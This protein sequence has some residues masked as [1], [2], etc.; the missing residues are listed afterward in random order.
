M[1]YFACIIAIISLCINGY[2]FLTADDLSPEIVKLQD[3]IKK[4]E[5]KISNLVV[6]NNDTVTG[7]ITRINKLEKRK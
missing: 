3:T 1:I 2:T 4:L 6:D 7:L 5:K